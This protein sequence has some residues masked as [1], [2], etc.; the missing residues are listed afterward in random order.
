MID[1]IHQA[2]LDDA[3]TDESHR[4]ARAAL[5]RGATGDDT[6]LGF[7]VAGDLGSATG[8]GLFHERGLHSFLQTSFAHVG[9]GGRAAQ[10]SLGNF[11]VGAALSGAAIGEQQDAGSGLYPRGS[12]AALDA[13][14]EFGAL[15]GLKVKGY[16]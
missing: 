10:E 5:G 2:Q 13:G 14:F 15:F 11:G 16:V 3:R 4:P 8:S 7:D 12:I 1:V 6:D 9:D